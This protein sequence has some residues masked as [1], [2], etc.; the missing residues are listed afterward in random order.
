MDICKY[1][2][3]QR[4]DL[5]QDKSIFERFDYHQSGFSR[6]FGKVDQTIVTMLLEVHSRPF[7]LIVECKERSE[8]F[9]D[10]RNKFFGKLKSI[11]NERK[12]LTENVSSLREMAKNLIDATTTNGSQQSSTL[13]TNL[14]NVFHSWS[15]SQTQK[16]EKK[17]E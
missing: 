8:Y 15:A 2:I 3:E 16:L 17:G 6:F 9:I 12:D 4:P 13:H 5:V 14:A 7:D 11:L 1:I 10:L